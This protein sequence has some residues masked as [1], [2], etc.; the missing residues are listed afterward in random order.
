M[1]ECVLYRVIGYS[2]PWCCWGS[3]DHVQLKCQNETSLDQWASATVPSSHIQ[4]STKYAHIWEY[5][6]RTLLNLRIACI[7]Y[8]THMADVH[9]YIPLKG[10]LSCV[11]QVSQWRIRWTS[12]S[13]A[14]GQSRRPQWFV[15]KKI[16]M[17]V[18]FT[19]HLFYPPNCF[20]IFFL[21]IFFL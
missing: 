11:L 21:C 3:Q 12:S 16:S 20:Y 1:A 17:C 5:L 2:L 7:F 9:D 14:L 19:I 10:M 4:Q 6:F 18:Q 15:K 13:T 8:P